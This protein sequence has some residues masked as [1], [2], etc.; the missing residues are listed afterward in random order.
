MKL[1]V[2]ILNKE[3]LLEEVLE[4]Y[5]EAGL[6]GATNLDSEG[7]GY[8]L[9]C[10]VPLF[11]G[12]KEFLKG[13]KPYNKTILSVVKDDKAVERLV[14]ILDE[15]TGGI[16]QPGTGVMFTIPVEWGYGFAEPRSSDLKEP[17]V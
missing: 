10:E 11:A 5:V 1:L 3:E 12:F 16:S 4:A 17:T 14:P 15:I 7:L 8:F 13:N 2:F 9:A 6:P